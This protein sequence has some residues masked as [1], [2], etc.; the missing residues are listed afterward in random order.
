MV[1]FYVTI[2]RNVEE[3]RYDIHKNACKRKRNRKTF[4]ILFVIY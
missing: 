1:F 4:V 3:R 2:V